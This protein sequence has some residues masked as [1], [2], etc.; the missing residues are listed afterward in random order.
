LSAYCIQIADLEVYYRVGVPDEERAQPQRLLVSVEMEV[1]APRAAGSDDLADTIDYFAVSQDLLR[2][3][4][5]GSWR[6]LERLVTELAKH[7]LGKYRPESVRVE[8]KKFVIP[9]ARH[10]AV[11]CVRRRNPTPE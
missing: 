7:V 11:S 6:L 4:E 3:G 9:Q 2:F 5:R 10:V 8:V 1:G